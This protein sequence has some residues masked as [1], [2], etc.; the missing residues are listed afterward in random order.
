M[1]HRDTATRA[2]PAV[3]MGRATVLMI[4]LFL[5]A[6]GSW[7]L[8]WRS[9]QYKPSYNNSLSLWSMTRNRV[10]TEG[11]SVAALIGSSRTL[12]DLN[13]EAWR[14]QTGQL[15]IQLALEGTSPAPFLADLAQDSAFSSL[16]IIGIAPPLFFFPGSDY[17]LEALEHYRSESPSEWLGQRISM[18]IEKLFAFYHFDTALPRV[19]KRQTFWPPRKGGEFQAREVRKLSDMR[20]TRQADLWTRLDDDTAYA[21]FAQ[22]V[23]LDMLEHPPAPPP[24]EV[25]AAQLDTLM[26]T[27]RSD[28]DAIRARGGEV[29]FIRLPSSD[30]FRGVEAAATPRDAFW[31]RLLRETDA[32]GV[33]FEDY[34]ELQN[35]RIPEWS[36]IS[37]RDSYRFTRNLVR[38]IRETLERRGIERPELGKPA[39]TITD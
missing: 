37:S 17:R 9:E 27:V 35:V 3:Q 10:A 34:P 32:A 14:D 33:H 18:P 22:G 21:E 31:D 12:F 15:P 4:V 23:W 36:H 7:E 30:R 28:I 24:P 39:G 38:I 1:T 16:L 11:D 26:M 25:A 6:F 5:T 29:V 13:L 2:T 19:L 20:K 8:F